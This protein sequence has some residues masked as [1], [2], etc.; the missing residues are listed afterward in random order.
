MRTDTTPQNVLFDRRIVERNLRKGL[1]TRE[2]YEQ[3][4][5]TLPDVSANAEVISARLG[6]DDATESSPGSNGVAPSGEA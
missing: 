3:Y 2:A 5:Q 4:L 6:E 1:V